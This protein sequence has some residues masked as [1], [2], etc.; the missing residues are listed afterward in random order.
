MQRH[1]AFKVIAISAIIIILIATFL[2]AYHLIKEFNT[3]VAATFPTSQLQRLSD[4]MTLEHVAIGFEESPANLYIPRRYIVLLDEEL[5]HVHQIVKLR[6]SF[7]K[8]LYWDLGGHKELGRDLSDVTGPDDTI[9]LA[10]QLGKLGAEDKNFERRVD[11]ERY[12][13][14]IDDYY[15]LMVLSPQAPK[16]VNSKENLLRPNDHISYPDT[17]IEHLDGM[18]SNHPCTEHTNVEKNLE[19]QMS[20]SFLHISEWRELD[21]AARDL[22]RR[23]ASSEN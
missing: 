21:R 8:L 13:K 16:I 5:Q 20:F 10:F 18:K 1:L 17:F 14:Q 9:F 7:S 15:G 3:F 22:V 2:F 23:M 12:E 11:F 4:S 6:L 19:M